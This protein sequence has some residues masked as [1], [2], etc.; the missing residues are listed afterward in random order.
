MAID[1][2]LGGE[3]AAGRVP[4]RI[5]NVEGREV[6]DEDRQ[7]RPPPERDGR[8][9]RAAGER[10]GEDEDE[11][12]AGGVHERQHGADRERGFD[13]GEVPEGGVQQE[14]AGGIAGMD[15]DVELLAA[16]TRAICSSISPSSS[17]RRP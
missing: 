5:R 12:D 11:A 1:R 16:K 8:R 7:I 6:P 10:A 2:E 14:D 17:S 13:A 9:E 3:K 4:R 15:V